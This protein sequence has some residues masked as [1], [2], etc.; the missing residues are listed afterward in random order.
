MK[1]C[2]T[3]TAAT[4]DLSSDYPILIGVKVPARAFPFPQELQQ[5]VMEEWEAPD[6]S[7]PMACW[8]DKMYA[9]FQEDLQGWLSYSKVDSLVTGVTKQTTIPVEGG[10]AL[11][12]C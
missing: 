9:W 1:L 7:L 11:R 5:M 6:A 8:L 10:A 2:I 12:D 3:E 4:M